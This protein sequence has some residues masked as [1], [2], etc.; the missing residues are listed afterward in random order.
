MRSSSAAAVLALFFF[1]QALTGA[2]ADPPAQA[3][4][5][6]SKAAAPV[7]EALRTPE[8]VLT[9]LYRLVTF[10]PGKEADWDA[11]RVLFL[12][13]AVVV[14]R[15]SR[16]ATTVFTLEG[17][18]AD[19]VS[20]AAKP[21]VRELGFAERIVRMKVTPFREVAQA[22]VLYEASL[23]GSERPPQR[24]VDG[25]SLVRRDGRWFIAS[26]VNDVVEEGYTPPPELGETG[27][28]SPAGR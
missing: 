21:K 15:T 8:G 10:P 16:E 4:A 12:P 6:A 28:P 18:V 14:L 22:W 13:E 9:E 5:A 27:A 2:P 1:S 26:I 19:F 23:P 24:G 25:F 3:P 17:F 11:V 7:P 20:F